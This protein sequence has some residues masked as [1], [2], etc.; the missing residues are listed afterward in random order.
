[1][2]L[3]GNC[4]GSTTGINPYWVAANIHFQSL[5]G[6]GREQIMVCLVGLL[7]FL[8]MFFNKVK[9]FWNSYSFELF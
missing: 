6:W 9:Y 3:T 5:A 4:Q 2:I 8:F 1:M 7:G